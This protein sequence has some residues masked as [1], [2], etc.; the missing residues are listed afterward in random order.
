MRIFSKLQPQEINNDN[1]KLTR[2]LKMTEQ[3]D[4]KEPVDEDSLE[5][6]WD[7]VE[8]DI[9]SDPEWFNFSQ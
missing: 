8:Q 4:L 6:F 5:A 3:F 1:E 7:Q 2:G 9:Q